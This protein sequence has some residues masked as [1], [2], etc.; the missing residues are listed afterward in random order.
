MAQV[1]FIRTS[2][3][4]RAKMKIGTATITNMLRNVFHEG[5]RAIA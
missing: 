4:N 1:I 2:G 3:I 5:R